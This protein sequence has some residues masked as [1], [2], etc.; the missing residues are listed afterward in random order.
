MIWL[1]RT[2]K[3]NDDFKFRPFDSY[4]NPEIEY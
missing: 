2:I 1:F 3:N 4:R